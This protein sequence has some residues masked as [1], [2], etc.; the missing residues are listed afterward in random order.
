MQYA[1]P[2]LKPIQFQAGGCPPQICNSSITIE[3]LHVILRLGSKTKFKKFE[4]FQQKP[5][6]P[7][8]QF[9]TTSF[10]I[11]DFYMK[12]CLNYKHQNVNYFDI[13]M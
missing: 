6:L 1:T 10:T 7:L 4:I 9:L 8:R 3:K 2:F 5:F 13:L 11:L 12:I